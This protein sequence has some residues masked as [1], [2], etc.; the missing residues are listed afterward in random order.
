MWRKFKHD[1]WNSGVF[2]LE[3]QAIPAI[4][5]FTARLSDRNN[6]VLSW[7]A[8][9]GSGGCDQIA[10]YEVRVSD[11]P[12]TSENYLLATLVDLNPD[13]EVRPPGIPEIRGVISREVV[14]DD[15]GDD[16]DDEHLTELEVLCGPF[17]PPDPNEKPLET[18][19][20][21]AIRPIDLAC[22]PGTIVSDDVLTI[23][24]VR[25]KYDKQGRVDLLVEVRLPVKRPVLDIPA[26]TTLRLIQNDETL[27]EFTVPVS[28]FTSNEQKTRFSDK[29]GTT[30]PGLR[31][32][33]FKG[34]RRTTIQARTVK[35]DLPAL[36]AGPLTVEYLIGD[37]PF[38]DEVTLVEKKNGRRLKYPD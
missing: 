37:R 36:T 27:V 38:D 20:Y 17:P 28:A 24:K 33:V 23:R 25:A 16:N 30:V 34:N 19:L 14:D 12:I 15:G 32:M 31:R 9:G 2:G 5:D 13:G 26:D 3:T 29:S 22:M 6:R 8:V 35:L 4:D 11:D 10:G 18:A 1:E 7:T 21:Y